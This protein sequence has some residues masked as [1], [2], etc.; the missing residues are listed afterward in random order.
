LIGNGVAVLRVAG[1]T[2]SSTLRGSWWLESAGRRTGSE[3]ATGGRRGKIQ[4]DVQ[5]W[6]ARLV[7]K[8]FAAGGA[9]LCLP[10]KYT[11]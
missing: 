2:T 3:V 11:F 9:F 6:F 8:I 10:K 7:P 4:R 1:S 5:I